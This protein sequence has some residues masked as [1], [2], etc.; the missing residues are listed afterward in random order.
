MAFSNIEPPPMPRDLG[1]YG[2]LRF[3]SN[4]PQVHFPYKMGFLFPPSLWMRVS[5]CMAFKPF[6]MDPT[7]ARGWKNRCQA[8]IVFILRMVGIF[9]R[10]E[11]IEEDGNLYLR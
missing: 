3:K 6:L 7:T 8:W 10:N 2:Y 1:S 9:G 11:T 4:N 5:S